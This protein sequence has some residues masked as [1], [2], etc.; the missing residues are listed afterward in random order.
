MLHSLWFVIDFIQEWCSNVVIKILQKKYLQD[1]FAFS[2][3]Q[4]GWKYEKDLN[5]ICTGYFLSIIMRKTQL[6]FWWPRRCWHK[7][8]AWLGNLYSATQQYIISAP[9]IMYG[10]SRRVSVCMEKDDGDFIV[11]RK[12]NFRYVVNYHRKVGIMIRKALMEIR[13][14]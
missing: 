8:Q 11:Q 7:R 12:Q 1:R 10:R 3:N 6:E 13:H 4:N 9:V 5:A 14:M 2:K